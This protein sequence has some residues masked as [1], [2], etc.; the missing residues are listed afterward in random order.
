MSLEE[1]VGQVMLG[2]F[3]GPELSQELAQRLTDIH[4]GGVILYSITGNIENASQVA[5]LVE[6]I[7]QQAI[8]SGDIPLFVGIDQEGGRVC[9]LT[10]GVTV[11]P[12]NMS[13]GATGSPELARQS[14]SVMAKELRILG[15]I[16][17]FAPVVDVNNNPANPVIGVRSFG[18][19]PEEVARLGTA[20]V[21]A[22]QQQGVLASAKHFPGHGD[23]DIDSHVALPIIPHDIKRLQSVELPPFKAMVEAGVPA[24]MTA[25]VLAPAISQSNELPVTL[26]PAALKY[27]RQEM[28]FNGLIISD[29][30]GMGAITQKW[31]LKEA[32]LQCFLA[33]ADVL[34]FGAD[35]MNEPRILEQVHQTL[36]NAAQSGRISPERLD[37]SVRR[38]LS[39]KLSY[40]ILDD[41]LPRHDQMAELA[42]PENLAVAERVARE[43]I[44]LVRDTKHMLPFS[45]QHTVPVVWPREVKET[46]APL[47]DECPFLKPYLVPLKPTATELRQLNAELR[48]YPTLVVGTYNLY[49]NTEWGKVVQSLG[50]ERILALAMGSPY[51]LM[52]IPHVSG[53]VAAYGDKSVTVQ[54]LGELLRGDLSPQGHLPVELPSI[55]E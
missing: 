2:C 16:M 48:D 27:L 45:G 10:E 15:I 55:S 12:G 21:D 51:D 4:L 37:Q 7:Q 40:G 17:N 14:A 47:L 3:N 38:I 5:R 20:M 46:L 29:S 11:F 26:S 22:Y 43:S 6:D 32:A 39:A 18:S 28:G 35:Q 13:L 54:A 49:R 25:H 30:L 36:L 42:A 52:Q 53:Y 44:T 8:K 31:G 19:S 34:L 33:G 50:Q 41:P 23:T 9:R 24:V 1:K